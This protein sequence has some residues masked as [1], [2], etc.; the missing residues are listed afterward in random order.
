VLN[1][2]GVQQQSFYHFEEE[3]C[4][5]LGLELVTVHLGA[6]NV[7]LQHRLIALLDAFDTLPRPF[8][9]H[10]KSGADRTGLAAAFYLLHTANVAD[11]VARAELSFRY[12][13]I[14]KSDTGILDFVLETYLRARAV[15][16]ISLRAW[17]ESVYDKDVVWQAYRAKKAGEKF[18]QG[19][20]RPMSL[21]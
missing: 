16:G 12:L 10:C 15:D 1:L 7:P 2:R 21:K 13:H 20:S 4:A 3:S 11:D 5:A 8:L 9:V 6:R 19:W 14:R 17:V 18:W